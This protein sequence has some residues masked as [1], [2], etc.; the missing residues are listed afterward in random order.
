MRHFF[1]HTNTDATRTIVDP[2]S[3]GEGVVTV[4]SLTAKLSLGIVL[5][6]LLSV[7]LM[8]GLAVWRCSVSA[9]WPP[10]TLSRS[11]SPTR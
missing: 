10:T 4:R 6:V 8:A 7:G 2:H 3:G 11:G 1:F 5:L 9:R